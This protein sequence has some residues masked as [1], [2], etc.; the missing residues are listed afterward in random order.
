[1]GVPLEKIRCQANI[2]VALIKFIDHS[3]SL[4][5]PLMCGLHW[6]IK[7]WMLIIKSLAEIKSYCLF[8]GWPGPIAW[9][10]KL[11]SLRLVACKMA[12]D[13]PGVTGD[14]FWS[15]GLTCGSTLLFCMLNILFPDIRVLCPLD[16]GKF[17]DLRNSS[18]MIT[19]DMLVF[20]ELEASEECPSPTPLSGLRN[21]SDFSI[22]S[23]LFWEKFASA[24][25]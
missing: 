12:N 2:T 6:M 3:H 4:W 19:R 18:S 15:A 21:P 11:G 23:T 22:S 25:W 20:G 9:V 13:S 1:M 17:R 14:F 16:D 10:V 5:Y 24:S 8:R 7:L